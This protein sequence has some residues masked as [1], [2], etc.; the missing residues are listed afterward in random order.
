MLK[1]EQA[2]KAPR[3]LV[4]NT[5]LWAPPRFI[6]GRSVWVLSSCIAD[7]FPGPAG[8]AGS[9]SS[10]GESPEETL[11]P[12]QGGHA[13]AG[14]IS[15]AGCWLENADPQAS[16]Q[17]QLRLNLR[18]S[19]PPGDVYTPSSLRNTDTKKEQANVFCIGPPSTCLR[20][21]EPRDLCRTCSSLSGQPELGGG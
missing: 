4:K 2:L 14:S 20:C 5:A 1:L 8:A 16:A 7:V 10:L 3:G 19:T 18:F 9:G 17:T 15:I 12:Q 13:P 21:P 11:S 6:S